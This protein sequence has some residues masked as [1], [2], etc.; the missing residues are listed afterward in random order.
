MQLNSNPVPN[1]DPANRQPSCRSQHAKRPPQ[2]HQDYL[3]TDAFNF[4]LSAIHKGVEPITYDVK[5]TRWTQA[6]QSEKDSILRNQVWTYVPCPPGVRPITSRWLFKIKPG[7]PN[8]PPKY[9]A[10]VVARGCQQQHGLDFQETFAPTI[11]WE[12]IRMI[13]AIAIH[14]R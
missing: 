4:L 12:S 6:I 2:S 9:K 13:T 10:R 8:I 14:H 11:R 5:D 7:T 3:R 1:T